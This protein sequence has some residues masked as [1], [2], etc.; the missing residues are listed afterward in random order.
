MGCWQVWLSLTRLFGF[1]NTHKGV[2]VVSVQI[3]KV[4]PDRVM[5]SKHAA[6][7]CD[8]RMAVPSES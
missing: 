7:S 8:M 4:V 5:L 2:G 3:Q 1:A 6:V